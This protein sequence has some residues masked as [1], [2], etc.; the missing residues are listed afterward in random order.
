MA[1]AA[2]M[3]EMGVKVQVLKRGTL[4]AMRAQKLY[5]LYRTY[6]SFD[7]VPQADQ[8]TVEKQMLRRPFAA[9]WADC[10]TY[11][12]NRDP[13]QIVRAQNDPKH[14]MALVF[15]WYLATAS[16]WATQGVADRQAD[17]Q[18]W[19]GP[20]MGAFNEWAKGSFLEQPANRNLPAVA[21]S[22]MRGA[23]ALKRAEIARMQGIHAAQANP[24]PVR[25][26]AMRQLEGVPT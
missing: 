14:Q 4:F 16:R 25:P 6:P 10:V 23:A 11:F 20:S 13:G 15:R 5:E 19:C 22:L 2:D 12:Q 18:I 7:A 21:N 1:A 26:S 24:R 17:F 9:V 8:A 3:F